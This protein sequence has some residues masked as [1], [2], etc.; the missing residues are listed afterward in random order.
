MT[1]V[2]KCGTFL[3]GDWKVTEVSLKMMPKSE[4]FIYLE[5]NRDKISRDIKNNSAI[6]IAMEAGRHFKNEEIKRQKEICKIISLNVLEF[7]EKRKMK[8]VFEELGLIPEKVW[9]TMFEGGYL[10]IQ[11]KDFN[12]TNKNFK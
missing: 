11:N 12:I 6:A 7:L 4:F 10:Y 5:M 9:C 3:G 8:K 2:I 1:K